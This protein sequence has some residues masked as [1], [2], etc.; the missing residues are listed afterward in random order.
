MFL[1]LALGWKILGVIA[2]LTGFV[3]ML[4]SVVI[5]VSRMWLACPHCNSNHTT[6]AESFVKVEGTEVVH[7]LR[8]TCNECGT[9]F[10]RPVPGSTIS[11][12]GSP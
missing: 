11:A 2:I 8:L 4:V 6:E 5:G 12:T 1:A 10:E 7:M 3:T 9:E